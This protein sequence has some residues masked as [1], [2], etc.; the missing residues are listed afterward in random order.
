MLSSLFV[1]H[2]QL[3][4]FFSQK[5]DNRLVCPNPSFLLDL[6]AK[7]IVTH[8]KEIELVP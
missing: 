4:Y 5:I 3:H 1:I 8:I 7:N 2:N 6:S